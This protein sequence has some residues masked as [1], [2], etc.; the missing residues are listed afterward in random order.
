[1]NSRLSIILVVLCLSCKKQSYPPSFSKAKVNI[2][3]NVGS[4]G[5]LDWKNIAYW[6]EAGNKYGVN[7]INLFI[8][9]VTLKDTK[10]KSYLIRDVFYLDPSDILKSSFQLD[11][12]PPGTYTEMTFLVG[13]DSAQNKT[14]GL[15]PSTDHLNMA[16]PDALG[17][18]YHFLKIEGYY[19]DTAD[20][21]KGYA[22][23]LGKNGHATEITLKSPMYQTYWNHE[24]TLSF[25][26]SEVF[27][28]P[29]TYNFNR[30]NNYT[31]MDSSAMSLISKNMQD[32]F[33]IKQNQ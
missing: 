3:T 2:S 33:S 11:S 5:L 26:I 20:M 15:S 21:Q 28:N 19:L 24:Y 29:H 22:I 6:N 1:M 4:S 16:W 14:M 8:S 32:A 10:G 7:K 27:K 18:G 17:G 30:D 9:N 23:H 31:M 12:I 13:L 25:D